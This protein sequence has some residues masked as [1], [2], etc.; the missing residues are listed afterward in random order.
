MPLDLCLNCCAAGTCQR[1]ETRLVTA[2][3]TK[4]AAFVRD[5][6]NDAASF[7]LSPESWFSALDKAV[8]TYPGRFVS[9]S[10]PEVFLT[11]RPFDKFAHRYWFREFC[12][13]V[14]ESVVPRVR[15]EARGR[16]IVFG[17]ILKAYFPVKAAL[18]GVRPANMNTQS[19]AVAS[20]WPDGPLA[21]PVHK[22]ML[23]PTKAGR[24]LFTRIR[25]A[26]ND[27]EKLDRGQHDGWENA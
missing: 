27:N 13:P 23:M 15:R 1:L 5:L 8:L 2:A 9:R 25:P 19:K 18:W 24:Q 6:R 3:E 20:I 11:M 4:N 12:S 21:C 22:Y 16:V 26:S 10:G 17:S 7:G 14:P